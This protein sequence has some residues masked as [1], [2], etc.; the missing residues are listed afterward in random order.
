MFSFI[1]FNGLHYFKVMFT[2]LLFWIFNN[3]SLYP[4]YFRLFI[5]NVVLQAFDT[6]SDSPLYNVAA[7]LTSKYSVKYI[8]FIWFS[9]SPTRL[10]FLYILVSTKTRLK[11]LFKIKDNK[12][13]Q[14][15]TLHLLSLLTKKSRKS[16]HFRSWN[17]QIFDIFPYQSSCLWIN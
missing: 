14:C 11:F 10:D 6:S 12:S 13:N 15:K 9:L 7:I 1:G 8:L 5:K 16:W 3:K 2:W 4:H 17:Q